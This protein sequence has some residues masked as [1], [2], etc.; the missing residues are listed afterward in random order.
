MTRSE[1]LLARLQKHSNREPPGKHGQ[2]NHSDGRN[3]GTMVTMVTVLINVQ[4]S[5]RTVSYFRPIL[6]TIKCFDRRQRRSSASTRTQIRLLGED[7]LHA[8]KHADRRIDMTKSAAVFR[9]LLG[10]SNGKIHTTLYNAKTCSTNTATKW[11]NMRPKNN[12]QVSF[13]TLFTWHSKNI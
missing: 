7:L 3:N 11:S 13:V 12:R 2:A 4:R 5:S 8:D 6:I 9:Q 1:I 10:K